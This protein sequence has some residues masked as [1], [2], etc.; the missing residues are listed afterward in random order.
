MTY[1]SIIYEVEQGVALITLNRPER[2]NA[3]NTR[4]AAELGSGLDRVCED[5]T[6]NNPLDL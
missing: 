6:D 1:E 5:E 3:W 4:M 2:L